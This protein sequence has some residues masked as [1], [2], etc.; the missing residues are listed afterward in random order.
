MSGDAAGSYAA[1]GNAVV[2]NHSGADLGGRATAG[3]DDITAVG[4]NDTISGGALAMGAGATAKAWNVATADNGST[5]NA[6]NDDIVAGD[7][8]DTVAGDA[9]ATGAGGRAEIGRASC[10]ERVCQ[11]V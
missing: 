1:G 5:A 6:G 4:G 8:A 2:T 7:G 11:Y 9:L 3:N 10:R